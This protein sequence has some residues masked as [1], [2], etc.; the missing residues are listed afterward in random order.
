MLYLSAI[1]LSFFLSIVL[2]TKRNKTHADYILAIWL[3]IIGFHLLIFYL[4]FTHQVPDYPSI[5]V[6]GFSLPLAHGPFLYLYTR[7]QTSSSP[8]NKKL[9]LHYLPLLLSILLFADFHFLSLDQKIEVFR[10]KGQTF[11]TQSL[12]NVYA[13]YVS[14]IVY[15]ILSFSRLLKYRKSLVHQFSNT[16]KINFTWLLYL[17]IWMVVIWIVILF[18]HEERLIYGAVAFFVLWLGFFGIRQVRVFSENTP[19]FLKESSLTTN[20]KNEESKL[21]IIEK[22]L[23]IDSPSLNDNS[24]SSKYQKSTLSEQDASQ[25]HER[26]M[27]LMTE[28]K[29]FKNPDLTLN[30]LAG[31]LEVH[32]NYLS[33]VI[34]SKEKKSFYDL[35]NEMRVEEFIKLISQPSN[36]QYTL[37]AI[38]YDSGFNSKASFNRNFKKYTGLTPRDFV[39]QQPAA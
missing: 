38:S 20:R 4:Y 36:Q 30:E 23:N 32:P 27:H 25:I 3:A 31:I 6:L 10:Q 14:G 8:F 34:N 37:L 1:F 24:V 18:I 16:E 26:L 35:I 7:Q 5:V 33:Q 39:K 21:N 15:I 19:D 11:K 12:I 17:I 13:I 2:I 22:G 29:P 28:Q 9:I